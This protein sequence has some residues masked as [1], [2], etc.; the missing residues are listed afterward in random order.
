LEPLSLIRSDRTDA[1]RLDDPNAD[2]CFL[3][4]ADEDGNASVRTLVL[5]NIQ[6]N[7]FRIFINRTSPKWQSLA[8]HSSYEL[9]L[10]YPSMQRQYRVSGSIQR[11]DEEIIRANWHRRPVAG[12]YLDYVY[13]ELGPQSSAIESRAILI[14]TVN[15]IKETLRDH[16]PQPPG[17]VAGIDLVA[18]RIERLDLN[19]EERLH[20]RQLFTLKNGTWTSTVLIP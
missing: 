5:R 10:W 8:N 12:K 11:V 7:R 15:Q 20:D 1:R 17:T 14:Q 6:E 9:L 3:A 4:L 18:D 13:E 19:R 16:E 2:I